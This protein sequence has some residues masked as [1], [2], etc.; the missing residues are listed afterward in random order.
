MAT[1][2]GDMTDEQMKAV[3]DYVMGLR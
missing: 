1:I 3:A 2:A